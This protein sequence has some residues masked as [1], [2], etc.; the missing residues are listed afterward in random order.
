MRTSSNTSFISQSNISKFI[1]FEK[2]KRSCTI[3]FKL[4]TPCMIFSMVSRHSL[5]P[6]VS[7]FKRVSPM[8]I[9]CKGFFTSWATPAIISPMTESLFDCSISSFI[10]FCSVVSLTYFI[11]CV[12]FPS[13]SVKG[14]VSNDQYLISPESLLTILSPVAGFPVARVTSTG[15]PLQGSPLSVN[16]S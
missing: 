1:G 14:K 9:F 8:L 12:V 2:S 3:E 5:L 15:H 6:S 16:F 7:Y 13:V 4:L 11:T 10:L